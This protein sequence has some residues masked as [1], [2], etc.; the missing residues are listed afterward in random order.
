[1]STTEANRLFFFD[2]QSILLNKKLPS[3]KTIAY[4]LSFSCCLLEGT[5]ACSLGIEQIAN[6]VKK[7]IN[8]STHNDE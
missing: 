4:D 6:V 3:N 5:A 1:M 2:G 7:S 8:F